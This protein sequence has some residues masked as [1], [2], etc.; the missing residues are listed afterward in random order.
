[1]DD[2]EVT[3]FLGN[4]HIWLLWLKQTDLGRSVIHM[5]RSGSPPD[6]STLDPD[7]EKCELQPY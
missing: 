5:D 4:L 2:L 7:L 6:V 1:M 3:P